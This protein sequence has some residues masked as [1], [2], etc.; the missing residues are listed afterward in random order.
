MLSS[1]T[2]EDLKR[3]IDECHQ[4]SSITARDSV[5]RPDFSVWG[6]YRYDGGCV[7]IAALIELKVHNL[8]DIS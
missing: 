2:P 6:W 1:I 4:L 8:S 7:A 3:L 5:T